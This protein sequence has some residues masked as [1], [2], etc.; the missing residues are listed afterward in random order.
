MVFY[1]VLCYGYGMCVMAR[2]LVFGPPA[3]KLPSVY[4]KPLRRNVGKSANE[5]FECLLVCVCVCVS[6]DGASRPTN[7]A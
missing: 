4:D 3:P 1:Y 7:F 6:R 5:P 2:C